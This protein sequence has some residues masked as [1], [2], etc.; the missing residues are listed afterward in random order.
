LFASL[1]AGASSSPS[2]NFTPVMIVQQSDGPMT[3]HP[4]IEHHNVKLFAR[5]VSSFTPLTLHPLQMT[6]LRR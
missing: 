6:R 1:F 4:A 2:T 5:A 3:R